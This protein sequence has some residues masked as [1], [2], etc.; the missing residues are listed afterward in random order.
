VNVFLKDR[1]GLHGFEL[2]LEVFQAGSVAAAVGAA[3]SIGKIEALIL[4]FFALDTPNRVSII[5]V[6]KRDWKYNRTWY[7][8]VGCRIECYRCCR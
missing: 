6:E 8:G 1:L 3:A 7:L 2:G 4:D 5:L